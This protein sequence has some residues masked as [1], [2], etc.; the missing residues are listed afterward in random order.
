MTVHRSAL[1]SEDGLYRYNLVRRWDSSLDRLAWVMLNPS[2]ADGLKDDATIRRV[3]RFTR[4]WGY[5]SLVVVNLFAYRATDPKE[6]TRRERW[7]VIG[8]D[9]DKAISR[10]ADGRDVVL[11]WGSALP[12]GLKG[13]A[14]FVTGDIAEVA[15]AMYCLGLTARGEPRHP[16][17]LPANTELEKWG[18]RR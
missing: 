9:N 10:E 4:E 2:T 14:A 15:R 16:L 1:L 8:D 5:G 3:E 13:R 17:Y 18:E 12:A 7:E 11:A 6:L